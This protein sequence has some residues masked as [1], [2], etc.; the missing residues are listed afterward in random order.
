EE[1][2]GV[3]GQ[4]F[5]GLTVQC[6]RCHDHK[7]D[8]ITSREYYSLISAID[9][10]Q[11]GER[12]FPDNNI[13]IKMK[14]LES[15]IQKSAAE[16]QSIETV[17]RSFRPKNSKLPTE[18]DFPKPFAMWT[19]DNDTKDSAGNLHGQLFGNARIEGGAL[20]LDGK[21]AFMRTP[22]MKRTLGIKTFEAW[23]M[24][25]NLDQ[26]GGGVVSL[27]SEDGSIFDAIVFGEQEPR[28]WMPGSD[29]FSRTVSF[30]GPAE[31][32]M[33]LRPVHIAIVYEKDGT[34]TCYRDGRLYGLPVQTKIAKFPL[35]QTHVAIGLRHLPAGANKHF[36][37]R[38]LRAC[39]YDR[40]LKA[41]EIS[42]SAEREGDFISEDDFKKLLPPAQFA[43]RMEL[44]LR[45][46][47]LQ[48]EL[49]A[50]AKE[51]VNKIYAI[52]PRQNPGPMKVHL[53]GDVVQFGPVVN[54]SGLKLTGQNAN[55][56]LNSESTDANRRLQLA[57]WI[58]SPE[59]PLFARVIVNR[60][61]HYHFGTGIV[62][63]PNDFGFNGG[64][65][66]HP[67]LLD[68]LA[69]HHINNNYQLKSLH[70]LIVTSDA[71]KRSS[72]PNANNITK[73][74]NNR[75]L[76]RHTP[77]R[78]EGEVLRDGMLAI[79]GL[80]NT[81]MGGPG[82]IDVTIDNNN[83]TTYYEPLDPV[84]SE[85]QRRTIYRFS[86]RGGRSTLLDTF[87]C[88]DPSTTS[89]RRNVTTTP[90]QALSLLHGPFTVRMAETLARKI[91]LQFPDSPEK[92]IEAVWQN[93]LQ[94]SPDRTEATESLA[95]SHRHGLWAVCLGLFN[96]NEF[97]IAK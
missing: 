26:R 18:T 70:R 25:D 96:T 1:N 81:Q 54:P 36:Q 55:W 40:P 38:V 73:D 41:D 30:Q 49:T 4:A 58:T 63:T 87:D 61:W 3:L 86:P 89:P 24:S 46:A 78:L 72:A 80:L 53:R 5:L 65:P 29:G 14:L 77:T 67:E 2:I 64:R 84:E 59:N 19:F 37:G 94:R 57:R 15:E 88:P 8:P 35:G 68:F 27:E 95:L 13:S 43:S 21:T 12:A 69:Q 11:H 74:A 16:I 23:V 60:I 92:Q 44:Q 71:Y 51:S 9:G 75:L 34:L 45:L 52:A 17:A 20:V 10:V 85:F 31:N 33:H 79:S 56:N 39:V 66:S 62:D 76:W 32:A 97:V 6:A 50:T 90:L 83:G 28:R 22:T 48:K 42:K 91:Q 47:K 93:V 82:F 7:F